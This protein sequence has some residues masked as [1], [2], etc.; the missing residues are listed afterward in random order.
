MEFQD[1]SIL[2]GRDIF[3]RKSLCGRK[4][5]N[6]LRIEITVG[7]FAEKV[8]LTHI[9]IRSFQCVDSFEFPPGAL[10]RLNNLSNIKATKNSIFFD[11][12]TEFCRTETLTVYT[13]Y[14][15][16]K[17]HPFYSMFTNLNVIVKDGSSYLN[18]SMEFDVPST[19]E[20]ES[21]AD[22]LI[23]HLSSAVR[24][25]FE[26]KLLIVSFHLN[27]FNKIS[28]PKD[29]L[30]GKSEVPNQCSICF[31]GG[32]DSLMVTVLAAKMLTE[33]KQFNLINTVFG[34]SE[35]VRFLFRKNA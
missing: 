31:S 4:L 8:S 34:E 27:Y 28:Q 6:G 18:P 24:T 30:N 14:E 9:S 1:N 5:N 13:Y 16:D 7:F 33:V 3:G 11:I 17:K 26:P 10:H 25:V 20:I 35:K 29:K 23:Q 12:D 22:E 32:V 19:V 2:F 21:M 15:L